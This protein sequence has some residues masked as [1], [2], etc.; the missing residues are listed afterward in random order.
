MKLGE[1][2]RMW[3]RAER[4]HPGLTNKVY[5]F[6]WPTDGQDPDE[7]RLQALARLVA[8]YRRGGGR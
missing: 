3:E 5:D 6:L 2:I 8:E 7:E 4:Q 1:Q